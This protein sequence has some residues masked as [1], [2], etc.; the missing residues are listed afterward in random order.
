MPAPLDLSPL[1]ATY[2]VSANV[3]EGLAARCRAGACDAELV[4]LLGQQ[5]R[6]GLDA[7]RARALVAELPAR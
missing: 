3:L 4:H 2:G 1:Q 6:G 5:D 7:E